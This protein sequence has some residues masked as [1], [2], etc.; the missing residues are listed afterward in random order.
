[1]L[2]LSV[3]KADFDFDFKRPQEQISTIE[4]RLLWRCY[5][6]TSLLLFRVRL[7]PEK[8]D[9]KF[10]KILK[11]EACIWVISFQILNFWLVSDQWKCTRLANQELCLREDHLWPHCYVQNLPLALF[12][13]QFQANCP[14]WAYLTICP[15]AKPEKF[16]DNNKPFAVSDFIVRISDSLYSEL[17]SQHGWYELEAKWCWVRKQNSFS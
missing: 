15:W 9:L 6:K 4:L 12:S 7:L 14:R 13:E 1:M 8:D 2:Q 3:L 16:I 10:C 11:S 5:T 17:M